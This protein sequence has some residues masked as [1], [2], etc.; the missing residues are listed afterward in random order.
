VFSAGFVP[1]L[2]VARSMPGP[3]PSRFH[4]IEASV[5]APAAPTSK[6]MPAALVAHTGRSSRQACRHARDAA[7]PAGW[8]RAA[9][10]EVGESKA[11]GGESRISGTSLDDMRNN[12]AGIDFAYRT[13]FA[14]C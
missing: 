6:P 1:E 7:R 8:H 2:D 9:G 13:I 5:S 14:T 4:A 10:L 12:V 3:T 11:D